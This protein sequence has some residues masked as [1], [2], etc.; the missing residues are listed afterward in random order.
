[1][2]RLVPD[3]LAGELSSVLCLG[4]HS[5]DIEI[6]CGGT[7]MQLAQQFP[8][9]VFRLVVFSGD[10]V[11]EGETRAAAA[12]IF[13]NGA[14]YQ[15]DVLRFED[16]FFPSQLRDIKLHFE[17]LCG[18]VNPDLIFTHRLED[19]HQDHRTLAELTWNTFRDHLVLEYEI[20]K[21]EGDLGQPNFFA[22]LSEAVAEA[23][24][25]LL[26]ECFPS[27]KLRPWFRRDLFRGLLSIRGLECR[28]PS[29]L[30][31][32]FHARKVMM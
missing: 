18:E 11:R 26:E 21:F 16:G 22:P 6:G 32:G 2:I 13:G 14:P 9:A 17:Q 31:E 29:G 1:V 24:L 15:V 25:A 30:A 20:P 27:Q 8:R 10:E 4:A 5:D 28:A 12:R 3:P 19:R 7:L 23:K